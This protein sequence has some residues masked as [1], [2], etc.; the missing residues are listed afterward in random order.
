MLRVSALTETETS[1]VTSELSCL[2]HTH[3]TIVEEI[4][5][6]DR[7]RERVVDVQ[8]SLHE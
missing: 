4:T 7:D 2:D 5:V 6:F 1:R 8:C 3:W